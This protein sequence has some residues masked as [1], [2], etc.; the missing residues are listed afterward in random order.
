MDRDLVSWW[1]ETA[2]SVYRDLP[3][4]RF[5]VYLP[6]SCSD[7]DISGFSSWDINN[8]SDQ[9]TAIRDLEL[10]IAEATH[11]LGVLKAGEELNSRFTKEDG[12]T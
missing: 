4:P 1:P 5:H 10:F 6:H 8:L 2:M 12:L 9:Q 7:W 11:A 3:E